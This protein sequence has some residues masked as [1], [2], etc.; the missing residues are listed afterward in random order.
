MGKSSND[1]TSKKIT[2]DLYFNKKKKTIFIFLP[3]VPSKTPLVG[4]V[5]QLKNI[6]QIQLLGSKKK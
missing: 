2:K 1:F 3:V 6:K 5:G 4:T